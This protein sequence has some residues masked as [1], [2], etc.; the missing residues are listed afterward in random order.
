MTEF[1]LPTGKPEA[2]LEA[3]CQEKLGVGLAEVRAWKEFLNG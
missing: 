1:V 3:L 2:I